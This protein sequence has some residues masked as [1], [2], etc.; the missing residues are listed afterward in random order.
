MP[1]MRS[2]STRDGEVLT[3][4]DTYLILSFAAGGE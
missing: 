2:G 4:Y 1:L 3:N